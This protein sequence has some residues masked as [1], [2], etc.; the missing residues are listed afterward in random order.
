[1]NFLYQFL[2]SDKYEDFKYCDCH[3]CFN[4][5][6]GAV[7]AADDISDEIISNDGQDTLEI[8]QDDIYSDGE[9]S[10]TNLTEKIE[11]SGTTLDLTN[12]YTFNNETDNNTGIFISKDNFALNGNG[13]TIDGKNISRIFSID[14]NN[15][16]LS[17]L[18]LITGNSDNGGAVCSERTVTLNN[19]TFIDNYAT[20][21]GGAVGFFANAIL[22]INN[23]RFIDNNAGSGS[24]IYVLNGNFSL[25]NTGIFYNRTTNENGTAKLNINLNPG[26]YILTATNP[27]TG[28]MMS[29]NITV[30]PTLNATDLEMKYRDGSKFMVTV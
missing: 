5:V 10:F 20:Q 19:I 7:C 28:L 18:I 9:D 2:Q 29:Y 16:T 27:L 11:K 8:M 21:H 12:D 30:L 6:G 15:I 22:N 4:H 24:S 3:A 1:M 13:H 23:S 25:Y 17:N 14:A 26:N